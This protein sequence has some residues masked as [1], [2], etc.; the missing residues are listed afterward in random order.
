MATTKK[1][2][3]KRFITPKEYDS[4]TK[5]YYALK[6]KVYKLAHSGKL[7]K[8]AQEEI[9]TFLRGIERSRA[10]ANWPKATNYKAG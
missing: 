6:N 1:T 4:I 7:N 10:N 3:T 2:E 8:T 9:N 5:S